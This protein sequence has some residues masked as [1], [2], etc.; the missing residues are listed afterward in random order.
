MDAHYC[1]Q[2]CLGGPQ[3]LKASELA[4]A[5][6]NRMGA[7]CVISLEDHLLVAMSA[8]LGREAWTKLSLVS[9]DGAGPV[10]LAGATDVHRWTG[11]YSGVKR[12]G[13]LPCSPPEHLMLFS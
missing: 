10:Q 3:L 4:V 5:G 6:H 12:A 7:T 13:G 8:T 11:P 9:L 1:W 2:Q